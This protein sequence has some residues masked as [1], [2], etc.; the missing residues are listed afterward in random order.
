MMERV[1]NLAAYIGMVL[2]TAGFVMSL[3]S[4]LRDRPRVK[5]TLQWDMT[6]AK[7]GDRT[8]VVRVTNVGRRPIFIGIIALEVPKGADP[9]HL[10]LME[11]IAGTK[12][13]EGDAPSPYLINYHGLAEYKSVWRRIRAYAEDST[14]KRYYS[15]IPRRKTKPPSWAQ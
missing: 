8:G 12:L 7:T 6:N 13:N 1:T 4:Y 5:L 3:M 2:G 11:S 10:V 15:R 14:G 9:T